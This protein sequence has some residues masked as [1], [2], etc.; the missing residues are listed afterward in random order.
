VTF[1]SWEAW[2]VWHP[3]AANGCKSTIN[4]EAICSRKADCWNRLIEQWD[5]RTDSYRPKT[6][7]HY[8]TREQKIAWFRSEGLRIIQ[9]EIRFEDPQMTSGLLR[10]IER[11]QQRIRAKVE[12]SIS[13]P[14]PLG[15]LMAD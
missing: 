14:D 12:S 6:Y 4:T 1:N 15:A 10:S 11:R 5:S 2:A 8:G 13:S 9:V 7:P 3:P